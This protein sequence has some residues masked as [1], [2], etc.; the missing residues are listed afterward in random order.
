MKA[1]L[2][3]GSVHPRD[4][5]MRLAKTFVRMYH[6]EEA[7]GEAEQHFITV[8]QQRA[9]PDDIEEVELSS[10]ELEEGGI[11]LIKLL[12]DLGLQASNGEARRSIQAAR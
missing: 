6:G 10:S 1:G 5:K 4:A 8:F 11:R 12:V 3:D 2:S 7:A 9:L